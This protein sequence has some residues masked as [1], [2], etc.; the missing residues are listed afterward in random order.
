MESED[1]FSQE[2][3]DLTGKEFFL[4]TAQPE[5]GADKMAT[6]ECWSI[7]AEFSQKVRV[8]RNSVVSSGTLDFIGESYVAGG[9]LKKPWISVWPLNQP[10]PIQ[11]PLLIAAAA[12]CVAVSPDGEIL[13]VAMNN[14]IS[15][16]EL[17][18]GDYVAHLTRHYG[19]VTCLAFSLC[20]R[21][22]AS[23]GQDG[24]VFVWETAEVWCS[25][26]SCNPQAVTCQGRI[27]DL[28]FAG[29]DTI[30][31]FMV[32]VGAD[33]TCRVYDA[34]LANYG[35]VANFLFRRPLIAVT[36]DFSA[37]NI[38][39]SDD[40]GSVFR[41]P[42]ITPDSRT[43]HPHMLSESDWNQRYQ[44]SG[45][46]KAVRC[47]QFSSDASLLV[48]GSDDLT[49]RVWQV[50]SRVCVRVLQ[51]RGP[52]TNLRRCLH[53]ESIVGKRSL[54]TARPL[55]PLKKQLV[56]DALG[57]GEKYIDIRLPSRGAHFALFTKAA[58]ECNGTIERQDSSTP[59]NGVS[60]DGLLEL[61]GQNADLATQL[62]AVQAELA[63]VKNVNRELYD[64]CRE[65]ILEQRKT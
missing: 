41:I 43:T 51:F 30:Y 18:T 58:A 9:A 46:T 61:Q 60:G 8:Y 13:V 63:T 26:A 27:E 2:F 11:P 65:K 28:I 21:H 56:S 32:T 22:F 40:S 48:T 15:V 37:T 31:S 29:A 14:K 6:I 17:A 54:I 38:A 25:G 3:E 12:S 33:H 57:T 50:K 47:M 20:G 19:A 35:P 16:Y 34:S 55:P 39:V 62:A 5:E 44:F 23:A 64:L 7:T 52:V 10:S 45:H 4:I 24:T 59:S 42:L 1:V 36:A 49:M 53:P